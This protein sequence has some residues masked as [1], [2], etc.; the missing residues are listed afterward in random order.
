M[1]W[2][3]SLGLISPKPLKRVIS[4]LPVRVF[5][6]KGETVPKEIVLGSRQFDKAN[7]T[8]GGEPLK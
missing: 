5:T 4:G 2:V 7:V 1:N 3:N 8:E 6:V